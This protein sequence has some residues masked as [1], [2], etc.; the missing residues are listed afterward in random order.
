LNT[1]T[2]KVQGLIGTAAVS[3]ATVVATCP[4]YA[5]AAEEGGI[6][7]I[8]PKMNEFI[9]MLVAFII[10]WIILAKFG[11]PIFDGMLEKRESTIRN[12]L[13]NA[14]EAR[15]ESERILA[16]YK[17]QL[18]EAKAEA[19]QIVANA[20][21]AGEDVK[22]DITAKAQVEADG[23]IEK[24]RAAIEAEKK[25]A[26][27]DLQGSVADISVEVASKV[28]GTDL[29]DD[30]HRAIIKRYVEEVGSFNAN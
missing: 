14:E 20:K 5:F 13:K 8:L 11:W 23:M 30:E 21:K 18:A 19:S 3:A 22:A 17:Q 24:A 6:G 29:S 26:I 4:V 9:P 25:A 1:Y 15:M 7:A 16:E 12:D 10:L 28:I 27:A 2:N